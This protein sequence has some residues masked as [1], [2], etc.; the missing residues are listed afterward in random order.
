MWRIVVRLFRNAGKPTKELVIDDFIEIE[1]QYFDNLP[2][3]DSIW[4]WHKVYSQIGE[5]GKIR[6]SDA[7]VVKEGKYKGK[8]NAT[9]VFCQTLRDAYSLHNKQ[10]K[11]AV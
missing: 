4:G 7:T 11:K 5:E 9:N 6:Y 1:D 2:I 8:S 3:D 10:L